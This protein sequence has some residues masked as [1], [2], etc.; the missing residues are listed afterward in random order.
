MSDTVTKDET[1]IEIIGEDRCAGCFG[2]YNS[3]PNDAIEMKYDE[4]S[5]YLPFIN[6]NCNRCGICQQHC[7][8]IQDTE[9]DDKSKEPVFYG[10]RSKDREIRMMSSSGGIFP[11]LAK[12]ILDQSGVVFGAGWDENF[13]LEHVKINDFYEIEKITGSKYVQSRIGKGYKK[14]LK[15][16]EEGKNVLFVGAPC[17]VAALNTFDDYEELLTID[18]VCH[19][20]PSQLLFDKYLEY[21]EKEYESDIDKIFFRDKTNGWEDF[22]MRIGFEDGSVYEKNHKL[23]PYFKAYLPNLCLRDSCYD[24]KFNCI[25]RPGDI[26]LGDFWGEPPKEISTNEGV[27]VILANNR[28][29]E[30]VLKELKNENQIEMKRTDYNTATVNNPRID[31]GKF[32]I[33]NSRNDFL[34]ELKTK[35]FESIKDKYIE[36]PNPLEFRLKKFVMSVLKSLKSNL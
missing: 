4:H 36:I 30:Q 27:S 21:K 1:A 24:C 32:Q 26:T 35:D 33:P 8:V 20:V 5:F 11:E 23:D 34:E 2:C 22:Q 18:L 14:V 19:G 17:Q 31:G 29:G 12:Y 10:G 7:P 25:P 13:N 9:N 15:E 16:L 6:E 28:K 3:C